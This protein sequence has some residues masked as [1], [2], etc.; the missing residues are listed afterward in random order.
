MK[1]HG[2]SQ[3]ILKQNS[4]YNPAHKALNDIFKFFI[5]GIRVLSNL[6]VK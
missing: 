2:L 5:T 1:G 6:F 4:T 3:D